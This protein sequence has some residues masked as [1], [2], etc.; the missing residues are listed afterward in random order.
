MVSLLCGRVRTLHHPRKVHDE[1]QDEKEYGQRFVNDVEEFDVDITEVSELGQE[2]ERPDEGREVVEV[3][4]DCHRHGPVDQ[5]DARQDALGSPRNSRLLLLLS[6]LVSHPLQYHQ[7]HEHE[8]L[9]D[10]TDAL[11]QRKPNSVV[12]LA[13]RAIL[14]VASVNVDLGLIR[15]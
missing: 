6:V 5:R 8:H 4:V 1:E 12:P 3:R 15:G 7:G 13:V 11:R 2:E 14:V 10:K 9:S